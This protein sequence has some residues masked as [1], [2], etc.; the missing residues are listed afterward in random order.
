MPSSP[1]QEHF[2]LAV[3]LLLT[4]FLLISNSEDRIISIAQGDSAVTGLAVHNA[5]NA[6]SSRTFLYIISIA[7]ILVLLLWLLRLGVRNRKG[8]AYTPHIVRPILSPPST[9]ISVW[10]RKATLPLQKE[11]DHLTQELE[12]L[13]Q[14]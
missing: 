14:D 4:T 7:L 1:R 9:G 3:A 13:R 12:R 5:G 8:M 6:T 2:F 11:F 10:G